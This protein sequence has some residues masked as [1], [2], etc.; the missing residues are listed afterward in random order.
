MVFGKYDCKAH[1]EDSSDSMI[2]GKVHNPHTTYISHI[3]IGKPLLTVMKFIQDLF[4]FVLKYIQKDIK[5]KYLFQLHNKNS[6]DSSLHYTPF[7][8]YFRESQGIPGNF[9]YI[10]K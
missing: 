1:L 5:D 4:G 7:F 8:F 6:R 2:K 3:Y 10:V 9:W